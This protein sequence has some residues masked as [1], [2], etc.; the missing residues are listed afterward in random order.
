MSSPG[1]NQ[2]F[3]P[4]Y[5][6]LTQ[7]ILTLSTVSFTGDL[8]GGDTTIANVA[9]PTPLT[10]GLAVAC[11]SP[12]PYLVPVGSVVQSAGGSSAVLTVA[13][14]GTETGAALTAGYASNDPVAARLLR[15]WT[16]VQ[17]SD[18]PA[19]F[20]T[21]R[22]EVS[23]KRIGQLNKWTLDVLVYIYCQAPTDRT[24]VAPALNALI[25][26]VRAAVST[27]PSG[28]GRAQ[29]RC[30]LGGLVFD[31]WIEGKIETDEGFLGQQGVA[32]I[33]VRIIQNGP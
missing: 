26:A 33:S 10:P 6:A 24:P 16:D 30:T 3:E 17:A 9:T 15:H 27:D 22:G 23:E 12:G 8:V 29:N 21:Q 25:G 20:V 13:P 14:T 18:Q 11:A 31:T 19:L 7:R 28:P 1:Q 2:N 32:K 5:A 4:I